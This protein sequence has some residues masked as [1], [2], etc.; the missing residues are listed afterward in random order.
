MLPEGRW[1]ALMIRRIAVVALALTV[2]G[3]AADEDQIDCFRL[4]SYSSSMSLL[5]ESLPK[6]AAEIGLTKEAI[7]VGVRSRLRAA[8]LY[9]EEESQYLYI[10]VNVVGPAFSVNVSFNRHV[11]V[12]ARRLRGIGTTW[13]AGSTG[14]HGNDPSYIRTAVSELIDSFLDAY[15]RVNQAACQEPSFDPLGVLNDSPEPAKPA[16]G[17]N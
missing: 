10:T 8:R 5:V 11:L 12:T 9:D 3:A 2:G 15:L 7:E 1:E 17:P 14:T 6:R 4:W 13:Q 16:Q